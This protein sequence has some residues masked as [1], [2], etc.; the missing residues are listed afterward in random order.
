MGTNPRLFGALVLGI[1]LISGTAFAGPDCTCRYKGIDIPEGQT[2]CM[3][4]PSG[5]MLAT[6]GRVLNNTSWKMIQ[7][8]CPYGMIKPLERSTKISAG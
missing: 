8:E 3:Q 5:N 7:K 4:L 6:C 2:I 1:S